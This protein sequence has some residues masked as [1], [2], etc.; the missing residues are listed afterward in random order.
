MNVS[1]QNVLISRMTSPQVHELVSQGYRSV[2]ITS[3][4]MEQHGNHL[5]ICT[6]TILARALSEKVAHR[7]GNTLVA[8]VITIGCSSHHMAFPGTVTVNE[9][10]FIHYVVSVASSMVDHGFNRLLVTSFHGGNF[11]PSLKAVDR[12]RELYPKV[13]VRAALD[14]G[15]LF[16]TTNGVIRE[17]FP[18]REALDC[19]AA[20]VETSMM[21]YL[22][23]SYVREDMV[24]DGA[25]FI[26][27]P[28]FDDLSKLTKN[29]VIGIVAGYSKA[30]GESLFE[31]MLKYMF[32]AWQIEK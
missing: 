19:H 11:A 30:V 10:A 4:A 8:P 24:E 25:E 14:L 16:K 28:L 6:D 2:I 27:L 23:P 31:A 13:D 32:D 18:D 12:I 3:G 21:L 1:P 5:P 17:Y 9:E 26:E 22:D 29:G 7:L 20:C 15:N